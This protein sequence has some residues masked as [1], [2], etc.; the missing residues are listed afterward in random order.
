M[1]LINRLVCV[2]NYVFASIR[3]SIPAIEVAKLYGMEFDSSGKRARCVFHFPDRY[4]SLSF[5]NNRFRC[6][7][8]GAHGSCIDL[9]MQLWGTNAYE[10]ACRLDTDFHLGLQLNQHPSS[11]ER[12][13]SYENAIIDEEYQEFERWRES[14]INMLNTA[15]RIG[16]HAMQ[17]ECPS[18]NAELIKN[19]ATIE[20]YANL[21]S[22]GSA[23]DQANIFRERRKIQK[24]IGRI[25]KN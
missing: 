1:L 17:T 22:Y 23:E 16:H 21:L 7:S 6:W 15:Y 20:Y 25:L 10:S 9:A 18:I 24:W 3:D 5:R 2:M 19:M 11:P 12:R 14:F 13:N 4:P 8:C